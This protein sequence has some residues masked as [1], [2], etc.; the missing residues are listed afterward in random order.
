MNNQPNVNKLKFCTGYGQF[1]TANP[2]KQN[3]KPYVPHSLDAL[4]A[5]LETPE[6]VPKDRAR[7]AIFSTLWNDPL[8]RQHELQRKQGE[9]V[10]A[11]GDLDE[12]NG[13]DFFQV[14]QKISEILN[15]DFFAY[16][17][18]SAKEEN[19]KSRIV[20]PYAFPIPGRDHVLI[21]KILN[22]KLEAAGIV[23]DM[24]TERAGQICYLPNNPNGFYDQFVNELS[25][26]FDPL[27]AW[28]GEL[29]A[30]KDAKAKEHEALLKRQ[31]EARQK[32][33]RRVVSGQRDVM[34][35]YKESFPVLY[36]LERY[37][38]R[39]SGDKYTSPNSESGKPGVSVSPDG[40]K[41]FSHHSSD[42]G[43]GQPHD[44]GGTFGDSWDLFR[45][46]E[47]GN[48]TAKAFQVAGDMFLTETGETF[49]KANQREYMEQKSQ[50]TADDFETI[51]NPSD[52]WEVPEPLGREVP[53]APEFPMDVLPE[54]VRDYVKDHVE[55][56]QCPV[57][58]MAM[59]AIVELAGLIGKEPTIRPKDKDSEWSE[60]ACI[61]NVLIS[62][63]STMKSSALKAGLKNLNRIQARDSE[64]DAKEKKKYLEKMLKH[65][66]RVKA[67][68]KQCKDILKKDPDAEL[69]D[70]PKSLLQDPPEQP[71]SHR[72]IVKDST[73]EKT[74]DL[75][76]QSPGLTMSSDELAGFM[77]NMNRYSAGS[78]RQFYLECYSGGTHPVDRIA[79]GE[80]YIPDMY[81]N[82]I[83]GVQPSV[84]RQLFCS[85]D[86]DDGFFERFIPVYPERKKDWKLVDRYPNTEARD[87]MNNL[88]DRLAGKNWSMVLSRDSDSEGEKYGKPYVSFDA[89][90]QA[91][92]NKWLTVHMNG[93]ANISDDD[94][95]LGFAG[96]RRGLLVRLCLIFHLAKWAGGEQENIKLVSGDTLNDAL[97]LLNDYI[98][99]MQERTMAAF[100]MSGFDD[101]VQRL[102]RWIKKSGVKS[103]KVRDIR[104]KR[105]TGF[106]ENKD[107][108]P[109]LEY[110]VELKWLRVEAT[111]PG[112]K[113]GRSTNEFIVNPSLAGK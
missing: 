76:V 8:S 92:F 19:P 34:A 55:R 72:R 40:Q 17:S 56:L 64:V 9:F 79:R 69:P 87:F 50:V 31:A 4:I 37:G 58:M 62:Q 5:G 80:Q 11:W 2:E 53:P 48:D 108:L 74:A 33:Q 99:P 36:A 1:H 13:Q 22:D 6:S 15:A 41:W 66:M 95:I 27:T 104:R 44:G 51:S 24:A 67:F 107:I 77:L 106:I 30:L 60:R 63:K 43:I 42:A 73:V 93:L 78:D 91:A 70:T 57:D 47:C 110:L 88:C 7:W 82:I 65:N 26:P 16:T 96:K 39:K 49:N 113:G 112:P 85:D 12:L 81:M 103:F 38:Y 84:A 105:W 111:T 25:G 89:K 61:W 20:A 97:V 86:S 28:A 102:V 101:E 3:P 45:Y 52:E 10:A 18:S 68:E 23:P 94:L 100:A 83:G 35:A 54:D 32:A 98:I 46:W 109:K 90:A 71:P 59:A 75:M 21:Q 14:V 29:K